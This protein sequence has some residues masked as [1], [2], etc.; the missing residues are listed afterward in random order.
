MHELLTPAGL[1]AIAAVG[2]LALALGVVCFLLPLL[3]R[4]TKDRAFTVKIAGI[5]LTAQDAT[6]NLAAAIKDLQEKMRRLEERGPAQAAGAVVAETEFDATPHA[7][8]RILWVDDYPSNNALIVEKLQDD[9]FA[10]DLALSTREA[11]NLF[12]RRRYDI[13]LSDMGRKEGARD[14]PDAGVQLTQELRAI[15]PGIPLI[16]YCSSRAR[17]AFAERAARAGATHVTSSAIDLYGQID[18]LIAQQESAHG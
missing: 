5:E 16:I 15:A 1:Q 14:V 9:G 13:V 3:Y 11:L 8:R 17:D 12:K 2:W 18:A 10:V 4:I 6:E 7:G